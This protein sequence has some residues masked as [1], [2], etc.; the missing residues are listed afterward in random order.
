MNKYIRLRGKDGSKNHTEGTQKPN[1]QILKVYEIRFWMVKTRWPPFW[2]FCYGLVRILN[3]VQKL[4][5]SSLECQ[6]TIQKLEHVRYWNPLLQ[7]ESEYWTSLV[8][9]WSKRGWMPN[10][11]V[12]KWHLNNRIT[13]Q[14]DHLNTRKMDAILFS[15]VLVWYSNGWSST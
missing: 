2:I 1:N 3:G 13:G 6:S 7:W 4:N 14:P 12:F 8:F 10:G 11:P 5:Y 15:Y 9:K